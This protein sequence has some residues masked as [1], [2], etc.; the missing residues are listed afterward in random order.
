M[1]KFDRL[2][3]CG[4]VF[5]AAA[6]TY[7][8]LCRIEHEPDFMQKIQTKYEAYLSAGRTFRAELGKYKELV[9]QDAVTELAGFMQEHRELGTSKLEFTELCS[10]IA[11]AIEN[12][13][14]YQRNCKAIET[15]KHKSWGK[16]GTTEQ[17]ARAEVKLA[18]ARAIAYP[19]Q[20]KIKAFTHPRFAV[21]YN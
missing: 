16:S 20:A 1:L 13:P 6:R 7:D 9:N 4:A 17:S 19:E 3:N 15:A 11:R 5:I 8:N 21:F 10:G 14:S 2:E 18:L 12:S